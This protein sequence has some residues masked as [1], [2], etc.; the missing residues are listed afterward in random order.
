MENPQE[1]VGKLLELPG[2]LSK[3]SQHK[4]SIQGEYIKTK[5]CLHSS[6][7]H[8][9]KFIELHFGSIKNIKYIGIKLIKTFKA[10]T[11]KTAK[12]C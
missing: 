6:N 11:L 8:N 12:H 5:Q 7:K 1:F 2:E 9:R 3:I 10:S 4:V